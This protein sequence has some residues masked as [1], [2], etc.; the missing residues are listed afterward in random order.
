M[1]WRLLVFGGCVMLFF[2]SNAAM[3][4]LAATQVTKQHPELADVLIAA[5]DRG[6][7]THRGCDVAMGRAQFGSVGPAADH[8]ARLDH[9]ADARDTVCRCRRLPMR[10]CVCQML[11]GV[12]AAVFGVTMTLVAADLTQRNGRF[13]LT[14]GAL[15]VA[16]AIG[17]S[18]STSLA[19]IAA[20]AL[21]DK[22]RIS[23]S[24]AGRRRGNAAAVVG[25]AG[26][27]GGALATAPH[28]RVGGS[29]AGGLTA[30]RYSGSDAIAR[31]APASRGGGTALP[32]LDRRRSP[33]TP[34]PR[35][36]A[37]TGW[38]TCS[39]RCEGRGL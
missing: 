20:D 5:D 22:R 4:P 25:D 31:F 12:S 1:D 18:I 16:I 7:A 6:A 13:N 35:L 3:L 23:G 29:G 32:R 36:R 19:G 14:L 26:D 39:G 27:M 11:G 15:G 38:R 34:S 9:A 17:A 21:G 37:R 33:R 24:R 10:C 8:A 2:V 30:R 28:G